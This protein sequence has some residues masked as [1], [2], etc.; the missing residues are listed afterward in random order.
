MSGCTETKQPQPAEEPTTE[1]QQPLLGDIH[2]HADFKIYLNNKPINF[3]QEKYMSSTEKSLS[4]FMH[5]H[6]MDGEV[7]HQHM[8]TLTLGDFFKTLKIELTENCFTMDDGA[9]YCNEGTNR[10][11][12]FVNGKPTTDFGKYQLNDLDRI[13]ITYGNDDEATIQTQI[14][15]VTDKACIQSE[16]CPQRGKPHDESTCLSSSDCIFNPNDNHTHDETEE[17]HT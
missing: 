3:A 1:T 6:D 14:K 4:N 13:L 17:G 15:S 12:M 8:S 11:K 7:I 9:K 2:V 5:L 10:L 16:K